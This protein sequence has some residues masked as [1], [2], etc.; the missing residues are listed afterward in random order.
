MHRLPIAVDETTDRH[1]R[2]Q[3]LYRPIVIK[4]P[5][6]LPVSISAFRLGVPRS[7]VAGI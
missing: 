7:T 3:A 4:L 5:A 1:S 2:V 6:A